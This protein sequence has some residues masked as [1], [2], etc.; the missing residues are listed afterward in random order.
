MEIPRRAVGIQGQL[1][2]IAGSNDGLS[3]KR[4]SHTYCVAKGTRAGI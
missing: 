2:Y 4:H 1:T 3:V